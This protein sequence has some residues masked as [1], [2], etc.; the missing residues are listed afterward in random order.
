M[1]SQHPKGESC[2]QAAPLWWETSALG[3]WM[4]GRSAGVAGSQATAR[5][6][7]GGCGP[8]MGEWRPETP[9]TLQDLHGSMQHLQ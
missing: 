3:R 6:C 2:H 1:R 9:E 8:R 4:R 7:W 5:R